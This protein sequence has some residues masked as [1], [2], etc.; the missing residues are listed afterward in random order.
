MDPLI[1]C[2]HAED[3]GLPPVHPAEAEAWRSN[4][5][6]S[7]AELQELRVLH[8][9]ALNWLDHLDVQ[10]S[11]SNTDTIL[12]ELRMQRRLLTLRVAN[13]DSA[14]APH[15]RLP[16][17]V[18]SE[19]FAICTDG[20]VTA[21][22]GSVDSFPWILLMTCR[23]WNQI[24]LE[25]PTIWR[26]VSL[27]Y[28]VGT[29]HSAEEYNNFTTLAHKVLAR[30]TRS[31]EIDMWHPPCIPLLAIGK[32]IHDLIHSLANRLTHIHLRCPHE[33]LV[34]FLNRSMIHFSALESMQIELYSEVFA[35]GMISRDETLGTFVFSDAPNLHTTVLVKPG[36]AMYVS[37]DSLH[38]PWH[39]LKSL[40]FSGYLTRLSAA[41]SIFWKC[42]NLEH[43]QLEVQ[44][45]RNTQAPN[46]NFIFL[47][48]LRSLVITAPPSPPTLLIHLLQPLV[49]PSLTN[50]D[51]R[52]CPIT[53]DLIDF[54]DRSNFSLQK[55]AATVAI[56]QL[57]LEH[58][59]DVLSLSIRN[60]SLLQTTFTDSIL[61]R[62]SQGSLLP[63][64][65]RL[66][67][68][69]SSSPVSLQLF[70]DIMVNRWFPD[71]EL[72]PGHCVGHIE[73]SQP[74]YPDRSQWHK[75]TTRFRDVKWKLLERGISIQDSF[76]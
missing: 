69:I 72:T 51:L 21:F 55:L 63:N 53:P 5:I 25:T 34:P 61:E 50:L 30:G 70:T 9:K 76:A 59:L 24:A 29:R 38:L 28:P 22:P 66:D 71:A 16:G 48:N 33:I 3:L 4:Y 8:S 2:D 35:I 57:D 32:P 12:E 56:P 73:Q 46:R 26:K 44:P 60:L 65:Q 64:I 6:L 43:C 18:L 74:L 68:T 67:C 10:I 39:R 54:F 36:T 1:F 14:L 11:W 31:L 62:I 45:E 49:T 40:S 20:S 41:R 42:Q 27:Q 37:P 19:I 47:R 23:R 52:G 13:L 17:D 15:K 75:A 58:M 7:D